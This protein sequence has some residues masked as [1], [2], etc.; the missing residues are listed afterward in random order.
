M[1]LF[2]GPNPILRVK[3]YT[4]VLIFIW[5][6]VILMLAFWSLYTNTQAA[7]GIAEIEARASFEKDL[8]YR[9][10]A[11]MH[12]GVY[13]PI[14]D[15]TPPNPYLDVPNKV[16]T[17]VDG[18]TLTLL[19]PAYMSRQVYELLETLEGSKGHITSL[20]PIR[21]GNEPDD[22]E[23]KA[24]EIFDAG[25]SREYVSVETL[26]GTLM[27][28]YIAAMVTEESCLKCHASQGYVVGD[29]RGGIS[30]SVPL[31]PYFDADA[32]TQ[33]GIVSGH[34]LLWTLGMIGITVASSRITRST[35]HELTAVQKL[36][37]SEVRYRQMFEVNHAAMLVIDP[38]TGCII[39]ANHAALDFYGYNYDQITS[40]TIQ[41]INTLPDDEVNDLMQQAKSRTTGYF[42]FKHRLASGEIRHVAVFSNPVDMEN[43]RFLYSI[44]VDITAKHEAEVQR[45]QMV[46]QMHLLNQT[47]MDMLALVDFQSIFEYVGAQIYSLLKNVVVIISE[48]V[49]DDMVKPT[50]I[51]GLDDTQMQQLTDWA[52]KPII[53]SLIEID[54]PV[55]V[56]DALSESKK[57]LRDW[58]MTVVSE[59]VAQRIISALDLRSMYSV[60]LHKDEQVFAY[61]KILSIGDA[62]KQS[63]GV[64]DS[65]VWQASITLQRLQ[66]EQDLRQ[67]EERQRLTLMGTRA[68]TWEWNVQTGETIFNER[69]AMIV[70]CTLQELEP[71]SIQTW[72]DLSHPDDLELSNQLLKQHF[73]GKTPYYEC[74]VRMKHKE[75]HWVWVLDR[76]AVM[77]WTE[78]GKP[79]R[80]FGTHV[81]ITR[82]KEAEQALSS[83][84]ERL[85]T[86]VDSIPLMISFFDEK[87]GFEYTNVYWADRLGWTAED[88]NAYENPL[89]LF[90]PDAEY[91]QQIMEYMLSAKPG[92]RDFQTQTRD[93]GVL[94]TSWANVRLSD[95]RSIGIGQDV[96]E[97][98]RVQQREMEFELE[99]E[100]HHLL[101]TFIQNTAHEF[102][103]PLATINSSA[104][105]MSRID[106]ADQ[107]AQKVKQIEE[108]V[109]SVNQLIYKLLLMTR[110]ESS[111]TNEMLPLKV[112][113]IL[114]LAC[115]N[116]RGSTCQTHEIKRIIESDLPKVMGSPDLLDEALI[117]ILDNACRFSSEDHLITIEVY[118]AQ[119]MICIDVQ[120]QGV[121]IAPGDLERVFE[122]FW[123][124]DSAHSTPGFGLGLPIARKIIEHHGGRIEIESE[125]GKGT[126]VRT[127]LP[128]SQV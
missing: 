88:L 64:I 43:N 9:R 82:R 123:R 52:G 53:G 61:I 55:T 72:I 63:F 92:W 45:Q 106:N 104:Y 84:E 10:W 108:Q 71:V 21:P 117:Q 105:L 58:L 36:K 87:G 74:E 111:E 49:N 65:L 120:D 38:E 79:L 124:H 100:R 59:K 127:F 90:Y 118:Q 93:N 125:V 62:N 2:Q 75:G 46:N 8:L 39:D 12:G 103:T 115:D 22:W 70:G 6:L 17:T 95:G 121:G 54:E 128:I 35:K 30:V 4:F 91:R 15:E 18:Q 23:R 41:Q 85:R 11:S 68:G 116:V 113:E 29:I 27:L 83:S 110:L 50:V 126:L 14:T 40:M 101:T 81:D 109:A 48:P 16:I 26:N 77:E 96:T 114:Q 32:A 67:T 13:V 122:T 98:R 60:T 33:R 44:I 20:N 86:I 119:N 80:M 25:E 28:R 51:Y 66:V 57:S 37:Q 73:A 99:Q 7:I 34:L 42:E 94:T 69:W 3:R 56:T 107:R 19:N 5:T 47:A 89:A 1:K 112:D 78:D 24:L 31:Q 76:G 97:L 102:R